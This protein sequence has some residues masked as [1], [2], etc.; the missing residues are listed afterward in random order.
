M[1]PQ[2]T[3]CSLRCSVMRASSSS[4]SLCGSMAV[5]TAFGLQTW[6]TF[7]KRSCELS[8]QRGPRLMHTLPPCAVSMARQMDGAHETQM[9]PRYP[10]AMMDGWGDG[11][12]TEVYMRALF[13]LA[14]KESCDKR[15]IKWV[16]E[17]Q[18]NVCSEKRLLVLVAELRNR[19]FICSVEVVGVGSRLELSVG[20]RLSV[21]L[22]YI[23]T[24]CW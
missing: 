4:R 17:H 14:A 24:A 3:G 11:R 9:V 7:A 1:C 6:R 8:L 2:R 20:L 5:R 13:A 10:H 12:F 22:G 21:G 19:G 23:D 18:E 16:W 15:C